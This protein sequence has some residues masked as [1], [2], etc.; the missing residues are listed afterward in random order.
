MKILVVCQHYYPEPFRITDIC[1][2]LVRKGHEVSVITGVPNYPEGV[3]YNGYRKGKNRNE[4]RNGVTIHRCFTVGRKG[5]IIKRL[6]NY[7]SFSLSSIKYVKKIEEKYD[8]V[9]VNQL[10]PV[11]MANA[12]ITYVIRHHVPL[13]MYI[14]DLWPASLSAGGIK[15]NSFIYKHYRKVSERIYKAANKLLISSNMFS[16]YLNKQFSISKDKIIYFPQYAEELFN[17]EE[18]KKIPNQTIDL[19]FAGNIGQIQS[20]ETI[21]RAAKIC[22]DVINLRW[23]IVGEGS[24]LEKCKQLADNLH[25]SSII[26]YGRKP[27][28][29]MPKYYAK[30]DAMLVTMTKNEILS[31]TLPGKVQS[32]LAAGKPIIGSIDGEA[33]TVINKAR[34]GYCSEAENV[35]KLAENVHRF[36]LEKDYEEYSRNSRKYY[37]EYFEKQKLMTRLD[38]ILN[39]ENFND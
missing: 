24:D 22:E 17:V 9:L 14:L 6:L 31:L 20:V 28:E 16:D 37:E 13:Y 39:N 32:Y 11:M 21:I 4:I 23:H 3:I 5:G 25:V 8:V 26:F 1:E 27:I 33:R 38:F 35:E 29:E 12:G 10:S 36:C 18:C 30:A 34:C 7:Y 19:M 2:E 15:E